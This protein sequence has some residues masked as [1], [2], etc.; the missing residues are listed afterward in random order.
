MHIHL[1]Q[2]HPIT[3]PAVPIDHLIYD[4]LSLN[5]ESYMVGCENVIEE[6]GVDCDDQVVT[7]I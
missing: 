3:L 6:V 2:I 7:L 5:K 1:C 4:L